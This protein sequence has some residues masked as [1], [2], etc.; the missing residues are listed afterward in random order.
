M[1]EAL[2]VYFGRIEV[3]Q[4]TPSAG[5]RMVFEY[6][7]T[8]KAAPESFPVSVSL[9]LTGGWTPGE[10][11]H[12]FFANLLPEGDARELVCRA[13]G[14]SLENDFQLLERLEGECAGALSL[15]PAGQSPPEAGSY[16]RITE[17]E[18]RHAVTTRLPLVRQ[19]VEGTLRLSLAG[20]QSKWA[21]YLE[22][23]QLHFP[24]GN[25]A[26]SHILKFRNHLFKGLPKIDSHVTFLSSR[27]GP[28]PPWSIQLKSSA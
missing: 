21:V 19:M 28:K 15:Y 6:A 12:R 10:A 16:R 23:G 9:P 20:A 22:D 26:S 14:V 24:E 4:L 13:L 18:L 8:W 25:A 1:T 7:D 17:E 2:A 27:L 11:D 5:G 3:G